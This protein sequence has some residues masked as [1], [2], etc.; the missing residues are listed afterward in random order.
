MAAVVVVLLAAVPRSGVWGAT[1]Y[2][3]LRMT[4]FE[5]AELVPVDAVELPD[6]AE[7]DELPLL[8][9]VLP[10]LLLPPLDDPEPEL[11]PEDVLLL[12]ELEPVLAFDLA[13]ADAPPPV[14]VV[15]EPVPEVDAPLA[16]PPVVLVPDC[17]PDP[18]VPDRVVPAA[19][20]PAPVVPP[21]IPSRAST[22]HRTTVS[23]ALS[24]EPFSTM[25]SITS[26]RS[27]STSR[28]V[29]SE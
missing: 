22:S 14:A 27:T 6:D 9:L 16:V 29:L 12:P 4:G 18:V 8:P 20:A 24:S 1:V 25:Y 10:L 21:T 2:V 7:L 5:P 15:E 17:P 19:P 23:V 3:K 11:L 13:F 28:C 26:P